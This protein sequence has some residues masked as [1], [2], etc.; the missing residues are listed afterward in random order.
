MCYRSLIGGTHVAQLGSARNLPGPRP[1][2][3]FAPSQIAK[4][5]SDWGAAELQRRLVASWS[6]FVATVTHP[7]QP[8]LGNIL[9][10]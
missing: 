8:R 7:A 3:F 6:A 4:R 2:L 9:S 5:H 1:V 10:M